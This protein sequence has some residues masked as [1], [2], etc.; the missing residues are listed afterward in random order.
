MRAFGCRPDPAGATGDWNPTSRLRAMR[1][2]G[3]TPDRRGLVG[4][5]LDQEWTGSCV[6][7]AWARAIQMSR[8]LRDEP[9]FELPSPLHLYA[10]LRGAL[11]EPITTDGGGTLDAAYRAVK[12]GGFVPISACPWA[13]NRV[14]EPLDPSEYLTAIDQRGILAHRLDPYDEAF[15]E[16]LQ[17]LLDSGV[18]V[19]VGGAVGSTFDAYRGGIWDGDDSG[20]GHAFCLIGYDATG[21]VTWYDA[22]NSWGDDWG[23]DGFVRLS[24]RALRL[25][26]AAWAVDAAPTYVR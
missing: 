16:D 20:N 17:A 1:R 14:L 5:I 3:K 13:P 26:Y 19:P 11:G 18:P 9:S 8:R 22:V 4:A 15:E 7:H 21:P 12:R 6:A 2:T 10:T 25:R 23:E 24:S